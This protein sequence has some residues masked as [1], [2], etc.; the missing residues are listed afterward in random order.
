[1]CS[2][3]VT[4]PYDTLSQGCYLIISIPG[5]CLLAYFECLGKDEILSETLLGENEF[6]VC[7]E[8]QP[9]PSIPA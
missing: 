9:I 6:V 1:M 4:F 2:F 5:L 3:L 8:S 7:T